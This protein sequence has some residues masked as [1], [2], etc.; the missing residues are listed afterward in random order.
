M[1]RECGS[2]VIPSARATPRLCLPSAWGSTLGQDGDIQAAASH[3]KGVVLRT[4]LALLLRTAYA[5]RF[6]AGLL[7]D[8][9]RELLVVE[10]AVMRGVRVN[11]R[12]VDRDHPDLHETG[13]LAQH[14]HRAEQLGQRVL[15][16]GTEPC[17][18]R[19]I[20]LLLSGD[21][22]VGDILH[23][24]AL[25]P[26]RRAFSPRVGVEQKR[27]HHRGLKRRPTPAVCA[28]G[29]IERREIHLLHR[30]QQEPRKMALRQPIPRVRGH[31]KRL[32]LVALD[33][34]GT[35]VAHPTLAAGRRGVHS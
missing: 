26:P 4:D 15:V 25:D 11:L 1:E 19:V 24:L 5:G 14:E 31:Q 27:D 3:A 32:L 33:L 28:V 30:C 17:D 18:R 13:L 6:L 29:A 20:G 21:H 35:A 7:D 16:A 9:P 22:A 34:N 10:V 8:L 12:P 2:R 23:A